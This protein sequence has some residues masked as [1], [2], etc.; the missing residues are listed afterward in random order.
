MQR[1]T[2]YAT[3]SPTG[4]QTTKRFETMRDAKAIA[5]KVEVDKAKGEYVSPSSGRVTIGELGPAW[6]DRQRGHMKPSSYRSYENAWRIHVMP[7]WGATRTTSVRFTDVQA[8]LSELSGQRGAVTV[9]FAHAVLANI[10][11]DCVRDRMLAT[12]VARGVRLPKRP[13]RNN[14]Y[15][16]GKQ[17][18][19][20]A[21]E[22]G[23]YRGLVLL[24]AVGGP[25]F[26]E[27]PRYGCR[28]WISCAVVSHCTRTRSTSVARS[29]WARSRAIR[30]ARY[31]CLA[32]SLTH[33]RWHVRGR[34]A[35]S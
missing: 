34:T 15:L 17:L 2:R 12:N 33:S 28:M 19:L 4:K 18:N 14:V 20:L 5:N 7:R 30:T 29:W 21:D 22:A 16:T 25:R 3:A 1:V 9:R 13:P 31:G 8:W 26:G 24:L 10:L 6:L 35:T 23:R 32:R 27:A 11:D